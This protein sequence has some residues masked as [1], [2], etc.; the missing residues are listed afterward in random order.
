VGIGITPNVELAR[1]AELEID[2]GIVVNQYCRTSDPDIFAAGDCTNHPNDFLRRRVRLESWANA[3]NQAIAAGKAM[4]DVGTPYQEIPWFWSD[5]YNVNVQFLGL[6]NSSDDVLTR[7][8]PSRDQFVQ[9]YLANN[10]LVAAA[11]INSPREIRS[12]KRLMKSSKLVS[13]GKLADQAV[14]LG[15]LV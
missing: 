14:D 1:G 6:P 13:A 4:T 11:A 12:A 7:G 8:D 15:Q 5:Q 2:D 3:Q 9:F 10:R